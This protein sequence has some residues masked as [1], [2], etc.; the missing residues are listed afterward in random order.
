MLQ[1]KHMV[2]LQA[3]EL[4]HLTT[5]SHP[6]ERTRRPP[7]GDVNLI[8]RSD[9][10]AD[11]AVAALLAIQILSVLAAAKALSIVTRAKFCIEVRC[12]I[13]VGVG[14]G[15]GGGWRLGMGNFII[16]VVLNS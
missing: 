9:V 15:G 4:Q 14:A 8:E 7:R 12:G 5:Q 11:E 16:L 13:G 6:L 3:K 2:W 1:I 10:A